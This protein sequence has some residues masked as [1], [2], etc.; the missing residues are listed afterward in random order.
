MRKTALPRFTRA[1][2]LALGALTIA[3]TA[4]TLIAVSAAPASADTDITATYA[5]SGSAYIH[6]LKATE[7]LGPGT[8]TSTL[9]LDTS[10]AT[11]SLSLPASTASFR[12]LGIIP[13]TATTQLVQTGTATGT[14]S[15]TDN[16]VSVT[17]TSVLEITSLKVAGISVPIG[18][19]CSSAPFSTTISSQPGFSLL[20]GGTV[21]G[22]FTLPKFSHCGLFTALLNLVLPGSGNTI[23]L[24][25]GAPALS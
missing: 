14:A 22:S 5:V 7:N 18:S 13:V 20:S 24:T 19:S 12:E 23:T 10:A 17:S 8:L 4:G 6:S 25:L 16:T 1:R 2:S 21:A 9:D 15:L 11:G 3:A